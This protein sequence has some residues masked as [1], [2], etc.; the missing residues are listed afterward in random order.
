[1]TGM[2]D[3]ARFGRSALSSP[4]LTV[5]SARKSARVMVARDSK[6]R[7]ERTCENCVIHQEYGHASVSVIGPTMTSALDAAWIQ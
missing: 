1:M 5:L 4:T 2:I 7:E 6:H 3:A